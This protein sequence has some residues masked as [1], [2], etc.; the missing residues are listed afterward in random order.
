MKKIIYTK[1]A[2][3]AIGAYSQA[4][5]MDKTLY[6]SGQ[7]PLVPETMQVVSQNIDE[8]INQVFE[9]LKAV[10]TEAGGDLN[11][12]IK[13]NVYLTDLSHFAKVNE[14]MVKLFNQPYPARAAV[15]ISALPKNVMIE[16]EGIANID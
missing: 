12:F 5:L 11:S 2:P 6:C 16:I 14:A 15:Q 1:N 3:Q 4:V 9:N 7:I 13:L 8:Q 10:V